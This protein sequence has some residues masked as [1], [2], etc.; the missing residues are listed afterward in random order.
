[1]N[2][3]KRLAAALACVLTTGVAHAVQEVDFTNVQVNGVTATSPVFVKAGDTLTFSATLTQ[4]GASNPPGTT[5]LGLCLEYNQAVVGDPATDPTTTTSFTHVLTTDQTA[6]GVPTP[7]S[8]CVAGG[9]TTTPGANTMVIKGWAHIGSGGWPNVALPVKLY[10]ASFTIAATPAGSTQLG[11]GASSVASGQTFAT[12]GPLVVCGRPTVTI[13]SPVN[14]SETGP[15]NASMNVHLSAA[16][17]AA[18]GTGGVFPV[19]LTLGGTATAGADYTVATSGVVGAS[20]NTVTVN[21]PA[22]GATTD[23]VVTFNVIDDNLVEGTEGILMTVAAGANNYDGVGNN[24]TANITD[25]DAGLSVAKSADAAE[26][27]TNGTFTITRTGDTTTALTVNFTIGGTA[28]QGTDYTLSTDNCATTL[29]GTSFAMGAGVTTATVSVCVIDDLLV[30]GNETVIFTLAA[31]TG[32][33]VVGGAA[34]MNIADNDVPPTVAVATHTDAAEPSTNGSFTITRSVNTSSTVPLNFTIG[35]TA[36]RGTDYTLSTDNCATTLA[37]N[38]LT[39]AGGVTTVT[40]SICVIDDA[41]VEGT[42]TVIFTIAAPTTAT[43]YNIGAASQTANIADDD[44]PVTVTIAATTQAAEPATNGLFTVTRSGG[45]AAQLQQALTVNFTVGGTATNGTDYQTIGTSVVIPAGATS[46]TIPVTVIDDSLLEGTESVVITISAS[47]NYTVGATG[48]ATVNIAD[49]EI[50]I[51]V[52]ASTPS[53]I[54][55]GT[56]QFT[57]TCTSASGSATVNYAFSGTYDPLPASGSQLVT[58]GTPAV[59]SVPTAD[60]SLIN[61]TRTITLT[62]TSL[63]GATAGVTINPASAAATGTVLDNDA[64]TIIPTMSEL[65]LLLLGL[66]MAMAGLAGVSMKRRRNG[67]QLGARPLIASEAKSPPASAG[68]GRLGG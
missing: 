46:A 37:G 62:I 31:G 6:D 21:F 5:G 60:D 24:N 52:S 10:D 67:C 38:S 29:G 15:V 64:P 61:G 54:E 18:C 1:M 13:T 47:A 51:G 56:L 59:I 49:D 11:F 30:E 20:G 53:V 40:V 17:P 65:G 66:M 19:T 55:G 58:C 22:D 9:A 27:S 8:D 26:P 57:L 23:E 63:S 50:G 12:N 32:Y 7:L 41:L 2:L 36:T 39:I 16:V 45:G 4:N 3:N 48:S 25:N 34:T 35:G 44:G 68:G 33:S 14:G 43:D 42:E 28:T